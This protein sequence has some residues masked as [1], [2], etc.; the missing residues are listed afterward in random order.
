MKS[1]PPEF[2][3]R[4]QSILGDEYS[5]F[6][7]SYE[8]P[9]LRS[10]RVNTLKLSPQAF[11]SLS[12]WS[13]QALK[14]APD[15]F[16]LGENTVG[17]GNHPYHLAGLFYMQEPSAMA[18][19][20]ALAPEA[21]MRVLD[22]CA[23]P[24]GKSGAIA[25][26]IGH[27]G[28]LVANEIVPARAK[29]LLQN[30][31]RMGAENAVVTNAKPETLCAAYEES[32]DAVLV[33]APC[34]GEG[35]FRKDELAVREWSL[36]HVRA[37]ADRQSAILA[38]AARALR[39]GGRLVYSTCTFSREENEE[40]VERFLCARPD[41]SLLETRRLYPQRGEGE[42]QF[43]AL[44]TRDGAA[45]ASAAPM[46]KP[47]QRHM[48]SAENRLAAAAL[49]ELFPRLSLSALYVL[50]DGRVLLLP[51]RYMAPGA[52]LRILCAGVEAG[53]CIKG[54]FSPS[55]ALFQC[56]GGECTKRLSCS[57]DDPRIKSFMRG[58]TLPAQG[59][60]GYV[61]ICVEGYPLGFGKAS[62]GV[63]K[64]HFP[65]GLRSGV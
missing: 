39:M 21:G 16:V 32:F 14:E 15:G 10:L 22:L 47:A 25:A 58:E 17:I 65:K 13:L 61:S 50:P 62:N 19:V 31:Q 64:N 6:L 24:G 26:R 57:A 28:L 27:E 4:M 36:E 52:A 23:A 41:F 48:E 2:L 29:I 8:Q 56:H 40:V 20:R 42:G 63:I 38:C 11:A 54:R 45:K 59:F 55:H 18:P 7:H 60:S 35:M 44:L 30:L 37:C 12:P 5:S 34:S 43:Y 3:S 46:K 49:D 9:P 1:L 51:S 33:D 53:E